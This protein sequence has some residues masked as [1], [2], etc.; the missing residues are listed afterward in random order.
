MRHLDNMAKVMLA[1]GLDRRLRLLDRRSSSRW[2]SGNEYEV[3][4]TLQPHARPVLRLMYWALILCNILMPQLLWF[5]K[6]RT[7]VAALFVIVAWSSTWACGW[8]AS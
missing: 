2:Y 3:F 6:V 7:N 8:S 1:T 5:R 4:M